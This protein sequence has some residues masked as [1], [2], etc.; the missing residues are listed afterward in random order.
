[1]EIP[2]YN[3]NDRYNSDFVQLIHCAM[4][5]LPV[6]TSTHITKDQFENQ[7]QHSTAML[8]EA[9]SQLKIPKITFL[10]GKAGGGGGGGIN[11]KEENKTI[12]RWGR[13]ENPQWVLEHVTC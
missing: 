4:S 2:S 10:G 13:G 7:A 6:R 1:M 12:T 8:Y 11:L 9:P 5:W 3:N